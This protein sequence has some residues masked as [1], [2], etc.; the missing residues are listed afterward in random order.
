MLENINNVVVASVVTESIKNADFVL[1]VF[2]VRS[3]DTYHLSGKRCYAIRTPDSEVG[4][5]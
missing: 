4:A 2:Y 5:N 3:I 1:D